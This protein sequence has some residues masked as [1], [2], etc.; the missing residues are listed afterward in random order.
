MKTH[1]RRWWIFEG[2]EQANSW[3]SV[4]TNTRSQRNAASPLKQQFKQHI[5]SLVNQ[6]Y[7]LQYSNDSLVLIHS[8]FL[9]FL[10]AELSSRPTEQQHLIEIW[11]HESAIPLRSA[12]GF[13][14]FLLSKKTEGN[15]SSFLV[16]STAASEVSS[17][18]H[19]SS[20]N[21]YVIETSGRCHSVWT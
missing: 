1:K 8:P 13:L 7:R 21:K 5:F 10:K 16:S 9:P 2:R 11:N 18:W 6:L 17:T 12:A 14:Y 3:S 15:E 19:S 20:F 4:S